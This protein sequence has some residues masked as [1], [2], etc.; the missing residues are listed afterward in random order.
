MKIG[1][2]KPTITQIEMTSGAG[3]IVR[4]KEVTDSLKMRGIKP[5]EIADYTELNKQNGY[6]RVIG[7]NQSI[8]FFIGL[9]PEQ[10]EFF[11][12]VY[13]INTFVPEW[14]DIY[15]NEYDTESYLHVQGNKIIGLYGDIETLQD[16]NNSSYKRKI[17]LNPWRISALN[18]FDSKRRAIE[19]IVEHELVEG[20]PTCSVLFGGAPPAGIIEHVAYVMESLTRFVQTNRP[21]EFDINIYMGSISNLFGSQLQPEMES[22]K[23]EIQTFINFLGNQQGVKFIGSLKPN[24]YIKEIFKS[25]IIITKPGWL[26]MSEIV[27]YSQMSKKAPNLILID[28]SKSIPEY[29]SSRYLEARGY[30]IIKENRLLNI[31]PTTLENMFSGSIDY[32]ANGCLARTLNMENLLDTILNP[33]NDKLYQK[34]SNNTDTTPILV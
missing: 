32:K 17:R 20:K 10:M 13:S 9:F 19:D 30:P 24:E 21:L 11:D 27:Y 3:P 16:Y 18:L 7:V 31:L 8:P 28:D 25:D 12:N 29:F 26:T 14:R 22:I 6:E 2:L 15:G 34:R 4:H 23:I 33:D 1:L 5:V